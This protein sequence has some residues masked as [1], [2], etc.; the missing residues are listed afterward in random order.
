MKYRALILPLL[1][2]MSCGSAQKT[3]PHEKRL[4][5]I[6]NDLHNA[7]GEK[8]YD[9]IGE[10][11]TSLYIHELT[12]TDMFRIIERQRLEDILKEMKLSM[13]GLVDSS[14][15]KQVGKILG[16]DAVVFVELSS[17][18]YTNSTKS[19]GSSESVKE[20][21]KVVISARV[22]TIETGEV[23]ASATDSSDYKNS[24][25]KLGEVA[26]TGTGMDRP[27]LVQKSISDSAPRLCDS[28]AKQMKKWYKARG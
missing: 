11:S 7:T 4:L 19:L 9:S 1:F 13:T 16:A 20:L 27:K 6:V 21:L 25:T 28:V 15:M 3:V 26:K 24:Y 22:V 23:L 8:I 18:Q 17:A 2:V 14:K 5:V 10:S 12:K